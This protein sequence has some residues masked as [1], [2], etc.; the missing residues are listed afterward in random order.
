MSLV[1]LISPDFN[2]S[3]PNFQISFVAGWS[4]MARQARPGRAIVRVGL[5]ISQAV[6][7][8]V[9][10]IARYIREILPLLLAQ[11]QTGAIDPV[12]YARGDRILRRAPLSSMRNGTPIRWMPFR[13]YLLGSGLDLFHSFGNYLPVHS[14][15][16]LTF[17]AHD[18][19]VLDV[20]SDKSSA[21]LRENV[22]RSSGIVCLTKHGRSRLLHH[23]HDY[24]PERIAVIPH[25]VDHETFKPVEKSV[26]RLTAQKHDL[27]KPYLI[28]LGS[29][30][31]HKNLETSI[32]A[33]AVSQACREGFVLAF[34]G[35]GANSDHR[36]NLDTLA[37]LK[38]VQDQIKWVEDVPAADIP[39][40]L[41]AS[42]C[43]LQPSRYEG[44]ALPLLEAMAVGTP[45]VASDSTC[46]PEVT[47]G[48]WPIFEQDQFEQFARHIDS[49]VFDSQKRDAAIEAGQKRAAIFTW[50]DSAIQTINFF[51]KIVQMESD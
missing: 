48:A 30:F 23:F 26:A 13:L 15:V 10:G 49:M 31:P 9:R 18:F 51:E 47:G 44:F 2:G 50:E 36:E 39:A 7:K 35:G 25:G 4:C 21:R 28:Q 22:K 3:N 29:W 5:D 19:R 17:T 38:G 6:K 32:E 12:L 27:Q 1:N 11:G 14:R 43:L 42:D 24:N 40:V 20:N 46:L 16:P 45:G 34:V 37:K 8:K 41:A 33:F